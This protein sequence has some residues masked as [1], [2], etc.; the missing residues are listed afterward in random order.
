MYATSIEDKRILYNISGLPSVK[1]MSM[2][3]SVGSPW[4][5]GSLGIAA[6]EDHETKLPNARSM[7]LMLA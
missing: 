7:Q 2:L 5:S 1:H 6:K 3:M 4:F